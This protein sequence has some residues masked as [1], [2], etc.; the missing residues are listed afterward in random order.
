MMM[1][2]KLL[3]FQSGRSSPMSEVTDSAPEDDGHF[4]DVTA[5]PKW[6]ISGLKDATTGQC[7][8]Q[9]HRN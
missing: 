3:M 9:V 2:T 5:P 8:L 6:T 1:L 7:V 4:D